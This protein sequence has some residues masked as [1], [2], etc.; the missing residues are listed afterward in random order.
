M[1]SGLF[2]TRRWAG[3][4]IQ[5]AELKETDSSAKRGAR[6]LDRH[7]RIRN[8]IAVTESGPT[9]TR[10]IATVIVEFV[11][12]GLVSKGCSNESF[13]RLEEEPIT[14]ERGIVRWNRDSSREGFVTET[15]AQ[16]GPSPSP[17]RSVS[18]T[19]W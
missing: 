9:R 8:I 3:T 5:I 7:V 12:C 4:P 16:E 1:V 18:H 14:I 2:Q 11:L 19:S 13:V 6:S 17:C 10:G 15:N